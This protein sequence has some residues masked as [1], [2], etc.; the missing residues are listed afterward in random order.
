L[1]ALWE[2]LL[3]V[4]RIGVRDDFFELGGH[5]LLAVRL[6]AEIEQTLGPKLP[7]VT[8][9]QAPTVEQL[10]ALMR[11]GESVQS[12]SL[13][14]PIQPHGTR[15]PLFLVHG[16]GGDVLWGYANLAA[17]LPQD[18]PIYGIKSRGQIGQEEFT[19]LRDMADCYLQVV[20][21]F[22]PEGPYYLGGYC[23]GGNVAYEMARQLQA[24]GRT[25]A[26]VA[27][28]DSA[29]A[30]AG[31][32]TVQWWRRDFAKRF[33]QNFWYWLRDFAAL[34]FTEQRNFV[35]RKLRSLSRRLKWQVARASAAPWVDLEAVIDTR[36][37]PDQ[38]L[39]LWQIHLQALVEHV[40]EPYDGQVTL[41]RTR[42]Q[43]LFC[44]LEDD[45]CWSKL[46]RGGV[47]VKLLPGSHENIFQEPNV[48]KLARQF[49]ESLVA[50]QAR[51]QV[52]E[53]PVRI[54]PAAAYSLTRFAELKA[55]D[56]SLKL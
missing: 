28:I 26:L 18:Q 9:F 35:A 22:Q 46:A 17:C 11:R 42:G 24:Q 54:N 5:S 50:A 25:V 1:C 56:S 16:A 45:F 32:E 10:A 51:A 19:N 12:G 14:V 55:H 4:E 27:L 53:R 3:R 40:E 52:A 34:A 21:E 13:L 8:L 37:F 48:G 15:P 7:L 31:Y 30:N 6:F 41:L 29:P 44:S 49:G 38:E 43:P 23:F 47:V 39:K 36:H 20:R 2:K 33:S